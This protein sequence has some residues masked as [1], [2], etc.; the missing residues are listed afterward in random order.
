[1]GV[2]AVPL[3]VQLVGALAAGSLLSSEAARQDQKKARKIGNRRAR[4]ESGRQ[5]IEQVRQAQIA[6]ADVV[7]SSNAQGVEGSSAALGGA[8]SIK[9]STG[10]NISF[11]QQI[12]QLQQSQSRLNQSAAN[13]QMFAGILGQVGAAAGSFAGPTATGA[14]VAPKANTTGNVGSNTGSF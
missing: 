4:L 3:G 1:M 12:F 9:S 13:K 11:A 5:A 8:G 14:E 2:A 10:S 7:A 6:R